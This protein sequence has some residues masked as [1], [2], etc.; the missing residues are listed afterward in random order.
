MKKS[1][2]SLFLFLVVSVTNLAHA[3][4]TVV[5]A[6]GSVFYKMPSGEIVTRE[7]TLLLPARGEGEVKLQYADT[8]VV[9]ASFSSRKENGRT[10]FYVLFRD[11]PGAP[12]GTEMV[13]M[14]TYTRGSNLAVYYGD[15]FTRGAGF[16][17]PHQGWSY[18]G[19]FRFET[20]IP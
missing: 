20:V 15:M 9:A 18:R 11:P 17:D 4:G 3:G 5:S 6:P 16:T 1:L 7:A 19:G 14:G 8:E 12:A 10:I 13:F 2:F